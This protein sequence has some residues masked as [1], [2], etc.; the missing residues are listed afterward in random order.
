M[1]IV[2]T[3]WKQVREV[4][5][6]DDDYD[7]ENLQMADLQSDGECVEEEFIG[8]DGNYDVEEI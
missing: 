7:L 4:W 8:D 6:V 3:Y 1:Q 5:N 2:I